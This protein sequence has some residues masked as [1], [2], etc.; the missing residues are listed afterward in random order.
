MNVFFN[1]STGTGT[2]K[3]TLMTFTDTLIGVATAP[4]HSL[5]SW[6]LCFV[7]E[8]GRDMV[9]VRPLA[10]GLICDLC[11]VSMVLVY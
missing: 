3:S 9:S 5:R 10:S 1:S 4:L 8:T 6:V 11:E 7:I 2:S